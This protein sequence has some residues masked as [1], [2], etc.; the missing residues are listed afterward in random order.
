MRTNTR[1]QAARVATHQ[2]GQTLD[3]LTPLQK[4]NRTVMACMLW[5][6]NFYE[7]GVSVAQRIKDLVDQCSP[8]DVS[9]VA[10]EARTN[11]NLRHAPLWIITAMVTSKVKQFNPLVR[12]TIRECI[13]RPDEITELVNMLLE[14]GVKKTLTRQVKLGLSD[15]FNKFG[16]YNFAKYDRDTKVK[17]RDALFLSHAKPKDDRQAAV[18]KQIAERKLPTPDTWEVALSGGAD[19]AESF[20]RLM[21]ENKLGDLALLR[22]LRKPEYLVTF[23]D[24]R[25]G[26][27]QLEVK[28]VQPVKPKKRG[29]QP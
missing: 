12:H 14:N 4:L 22:N 7:S 15:A 10:I 21:R 18:F 3:N 1:A 6:N 11:Q 27:M 26:P 2:G 24:N 13:Q 23:K 25:D 20:A 29:K 5:E 17:L 9:R 19:K 8:L 28:K 16:A